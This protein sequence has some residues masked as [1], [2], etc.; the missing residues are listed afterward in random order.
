MKNR[1]S[2]MVAAVLVLSGIVLSPASVGAQSEKVKKFDP[3][4][5]VP[6]LPNGK[7]DFS[8]NWTRPGT[9]DITRTFK[10]ANGTSNKGEPNPLPF[11]TWGQKQWDNYN[12]V[13]N[14]D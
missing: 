8:G 1:L 14:G 13:K 3:K 7:P 11:T 9:M 6:R 4:A 5:P 12:P 2:V 10:N